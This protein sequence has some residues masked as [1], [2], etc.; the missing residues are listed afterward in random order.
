LQLGAHRADGLAVHMEQQVA[1]GA[2]VGPSA[3]D[4]GTGLSE[5]RYLVRLPVP[6]SRSPPRAA[7]TCPR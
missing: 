6:R 4:N 5:K 7:S 2:P 3:F 1:V